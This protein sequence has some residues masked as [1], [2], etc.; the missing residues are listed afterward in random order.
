MMRIGAILWIVVAV[1]NF[2]L[3]LIVVGAWPVPYV[4]AEHT[5]SELG[6]TSCGPQERASGTLETCSPRH[7]LLNAGG[8]V[9]YSLLGLGGW[10]LR[11]L[12]HRS[13]LITA[14]FVAITVGGIAVSVIPGDVNITAH[15]LWALPLLLGG[16][17][18]QLLAAA[19]MRRSSPRLVAF[20]AVTGLIS[21]A[22][23]I[24][25]GFALSG[26]GLIGY[27]ERVSAET[28][29]LWL[30]V[31][32]LAVLIRPGLRSGASDRRHGS[33]GFGTVR[34]RTGR[35][36]GWP[37]EGTPDA[38]VPVD[39]MG[40]ASGD[41]PPLLTSSRLAAQ[42]TGVERLRTDD[43]KRLR[44]LR[45]Q[46]RV[47]MDLESATLVLH[48]RDHDIGHHSSDHG[49]GF[50]VQTDPSCGQAPSIP[51]TGE[52]HSRLDRQRESRAVLVGVQHGIRPFSNTEPIA[53]PAPATR[54][55]DRRAGL[56][57]S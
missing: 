50:V 56:R 29:Y 23:T 25:L 16:L 40:I 17:V 20:S 45:R 42:V 44:R 43:P 19:K 21:V 4:L 39:G 31:I 33:A 18:V 12:W 51:G 3:Q 15:A 57:R 46:V 30:F 8:V 1:G 38:P 2:A 24:W 55:P 54:G 5:V 48:P 41:P 11:P 37:G 27:A 52:G 10:L 34:L 47:G 14:G 26:A 49:L 6:Y 28:I 53:S 9:Q 7:M 35:S 32:G 22:G 36:F 13:R